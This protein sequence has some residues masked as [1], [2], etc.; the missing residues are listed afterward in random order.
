M[1]FSVLGKSSAIPVCLSEFCL[2]HDV[3]CALFYCPSKNLTLR[4]PSKWLRGTQKCPCDRRLVSL[5]PLGVVYRQ[6]GGNSWDEPVVRRSEVFSRPG[7]H[8][9][10]T[11]MW[12]RAVL[13]IWRDWSGAGSTIQESCCRYLASWS[14]ALPFLT[15]TPRATAIIW[16][17]FIA[18]SRL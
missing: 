16:M 17:L 7:A 4:L 5:F 18:G 15:P 6:V 10:N 9:R 3:T 13:F 2:S 11:K 14:P 12:S 1:C 8:I